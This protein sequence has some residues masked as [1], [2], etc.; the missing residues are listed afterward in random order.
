MKKLIVL[1]L[2]A[3]GAYAQNVVQDISNVKKPSEGKLYYSKKDKGLYLYRNDFVEISKATINPT[4]IVPPVVL[5][6]QEEIQLGYWDVPERIL[7]AK[8]LGGQYYLLQTNKERSYYVPRGID[9]LQDKRTKKN[10]SIPNNIVSLKSELGGL[11]PPANFPEAEIIRLGYYKNEQSEYIPK[12]INPTIQIT[13]KV[14]PPIITYPKDI[15]LSYWIQDANDWLNCD[16]INPYYPNCNSFGYIAQSNG[17]MGRIKNFMR[18]DLTKPPFY[19]TYHPVKSIVGGDGSTGDTDY[20]V[21]FNQEAFDKTLAYA[22]ECGAKAFEFYFYDNDADVSEHIKF[23]QTTNSPYKDFVQYHYA[24][25]SMGYTA[26]TTMNRIVS[27]MSQSRYYKINKRPVLVIDNPNEKKFH[28]DR[29]ILQSGATLKYDNVENVNYYE[30]NADYTGPI[31]FFPEPGYVRSSG[32]T[33]FQNFIEYINS[34][35]KALHKQ[36]VYLITQGSFFYQDRNDTVLNEDAV[37]AYSAPPPNMTTDHSY[38]NLVAHNIST[39]N[40]ILASGQRVVPVITTGFENIYINGQVEYYT[41]AG[42]PAEIIEHMNSVKDIVRANL[43]KIPFVKIYSFGESNEA[44]GGALV[45][46]RNLDGSI[47]KTMITAV[48][49]GISN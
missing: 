44:G 42:T 4:V 12:A 37:S 1:L 6:K 34:Q 21:T 8:L 46:R 9:L 31:K 30:Q 20:N 13:E 33:P 17:A 29:Y 18:R 35:Y 47:D 48:R 39:L 7:V 38:S 41:N 40:T 26:V 27:H 23:N 5:N 2:I 15:V 22:Y 45:P 32:E 11:Y 16:P 3:F 25:G 24:I 28:T 19:A 10:E 43:D 14:T 36:N 49:T